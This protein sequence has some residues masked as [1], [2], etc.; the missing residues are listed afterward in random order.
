MKIAVFSDSHIG[1]SYGDVPRDDDMAA[2]INAVITGIEKAGVDR[3]AVLG[4]TFDSPTPS[5]AALRMGMAMLT[6]LAVIAPVTVLAGNHDVMERDDLHDGLA[7]V[8]AAGNDRITILRDISYACLGGI[9]IPHLPRWTDTQGDVNARIRE[10][11]QTGID[12]GCRLWWGH[13]NIAGAKLGAADVY[14]RGHSGSRKPTW[15]T[16]LLR[17]ATV[18]VPGSLVRMGF[19]EAG[20]R[21]SWM[22]LDTEA[23]RGVHVLNGHFHRE[24]S[25]VIA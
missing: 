10:A 1:L 8:E 22:V 24:Q 12:R 16:D 2:A 14:E 18:H 3:V 20:D 6:R 11:V 23:M 21:K 7:V 4:D 19:S 25:W 17:G 5:T 9:A 15:P 13:L